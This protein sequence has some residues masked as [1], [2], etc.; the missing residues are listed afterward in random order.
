MLKCT[1]KRIH[2]WP[3]LTLALALTVEAYGP[4][5]LSF[6]KVTVHRDF[7]CETALAADI[8]KDGVKD[9]VS[10]PYWYQ[11]PT[12]AKKT[13]LY[14]YKPVNPFTLAPVPKYDPRSSSNN[15]FQWAYDLNNDGWIDIITHTYPGRQAVWHENPKGQPGLWK[16]HLIYDVVNGEQNMFADITG[17]GKP[18]ILC[19]SASQPGYLEPDWTQITSKWNWRPIAPKDGKWAEK[20]WHGMGYGDINGDGRQDMLHTSGFLIQPAGAAGS[21]N[22]TLIPQRFY[23]DMGE[24]EGTSHMYTAD[25]DGDGDHDLIAAKESHGEGLSWWENRD[26]KGV[27]MIENKIM[28]TKAEGVAK[29]GIWFTQLHS[30]Q[31]A[32]LDNDGEKDIIS[33]K[34]F[35]AHPPGGIDKDAEGIPYVAWWKK[36]LN[37]G[38]VTWTPFVIDSTDGI[39][40][41]L[42]IQ[43]IDGNGGLDIIVGNKRGLFVYFR[44]GTIPILAAPQKRA[45]AWNL[46]QLKQKMGWFSVRGRVEKNAPTSTTQSLR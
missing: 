41:Q 9:L 3:S 39:G 29:Y 11:G 19:F 23:G 36:S 13:E 45:P 14:P 18:E 27:N 32:D 16:E 40:R 22:W 15:W 5:P 44:E 10:G 42:N 2:F 6:R 12:F 1:C 37:A 4:N 8:D 28:G 34:T 21:T 46:Q 30:L 31:F 25:L 20:Y 43:D 33:G 26:G 17:D 7:F 38:K 35:W 24:K